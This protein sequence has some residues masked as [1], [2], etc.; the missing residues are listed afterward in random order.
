MPDVALTALGYHLAHLPLD[1]RL[2]KML[3]LGAVLQCVDPVL[4]VCAALAGK[5]PF[6]RGARNVDDEKARHA[7]LGSDHLAIVRVYNEWAAVG[8]AAATSAAPPTAGANVPSNAASSSSSARSS[9]GGEQQRA[10][11][12]WC[13]QHCVSHEALSAMRDVR[14]QFRQQLSDIGFCPR[15]PPRKTTQQ[16]HRM[17]SSSSPPPREVLA[18]FFFGATLR[19]KTLAPLRA[20]V[21]ELAYAV[22]SLPV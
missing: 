5:S 7:A 1:A 9:R 8:A 20:A 21:R 11:R 13:Q 17:S 16:Q 6:L 10:Q 3:V 15:L 14:T 2:G 19:M 12:Q 18:A 4:T 22:F